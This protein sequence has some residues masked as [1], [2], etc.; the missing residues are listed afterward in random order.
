M[1]SVSCFGQS[2][3]ISDEDV[4]INK[5]MAE[6]SATLINDGDAVIHPATAVTWLWIGAPRA[7]VIRTAHKTKARKIHVLVDERLVHVW[8]APHRLGG[9]QYG[10]LMR[11]ISD[12]C[13]LAFHEAGNKAQKKMLLART[14][15]L[16]T[17]MLPTKSARI[18]YHLPRMIMVPA[19][20]VV[21]TSTVD[22]S[23]ANGDLIPIEERDPEGCLV[24]NSGETR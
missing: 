5:R 17:A 9:E 22:L 16:Q 14:A 2:Q 6:H 7:G 12:N 8:G 4:E 24:R 20:S 19:Y 10:F 18:C 13:R 1:N 3:R 15:L 23:L 21:P 11:I